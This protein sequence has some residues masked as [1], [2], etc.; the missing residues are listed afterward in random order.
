MQRVAVTGADGFIGSHLCELLLKRGFTVRAA[1]Q[2]NSFNSWGWLD[3]TP[4][5]Q[6][7]EVL[8]G[9]VRDVHFCNRI[10]SGVDI[11]FHLAALVA[12]PYSYVSPDSYFDVNVKG[13]L[14][15]CQAAK[16]KNNV[17]VV[18]M[19]TSEVYGTAK[20]VP[21]DEKHPFQ[22][23]S[24][25]SASK[26]SA[27]AIAMSFFNSFELPLTIARPFNTYGPRQ[28]ARAVI[29]AIIS[30]IAAGNDK[31]N[32]GDLLPTRDFSFVTDTCDALIRVAT[33]NRTLGRSVN[34]GSNAEISIGGLVKLI[35]D[36]MGTNVEVLADKQRF[37]A[38]KSEVERLWCNN[39]LANDLVSYQPRVSLKEGL[40]KTIDWFQRDE[41]LKKYKTQIYNI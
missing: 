38:P 25:Y 7:M 27:D 4:A 16:S 6:N 5:S 19:S 40:I 12:I 21:I 30:Q 39:K 31:I 15:I 23:Q 8:A 18:H 36:I 1:V 17:R 26:I 34:I 9:D 14:N 20:Y 2:Y 3:E 28:S 10:C 22:P 33:S 35:Q 32:L 37:R 29:P 24:P 11:V 41:N 13:T